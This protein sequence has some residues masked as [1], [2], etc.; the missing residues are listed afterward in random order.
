MGMTLAAKVAA[1]CRELGDESDDGL[2]ALARKQH[3]GSVFTDAA[4]ALRAGQLTPELEANLDSLDEMVRRAEGQGFYPA[5]TRGFA[6]LPGS[7][8]SSLPGSGGGTGAQWWTCPQN[9]CAGRG[10]V[11]PGQPTPRCAATGED[12]APGPLPE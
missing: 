4:N 5:V 11:K 3:M 1:F 12:L 2:A 7:G 6:P 8:Y 10:R 9:R